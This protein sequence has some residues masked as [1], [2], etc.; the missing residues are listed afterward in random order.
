MIAAGTSPLGE[1]WTFKV[2][3]TPEA[4]ERQASES[5]EITYR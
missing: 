1:D 4:D 2:T 3:F 5:K